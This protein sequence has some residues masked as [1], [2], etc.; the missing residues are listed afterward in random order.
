MAKEKKEIQQEEKDVREK[1]K[2]T[3]LKETVEREDLKKRRG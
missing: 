2:K 1:E 3:A